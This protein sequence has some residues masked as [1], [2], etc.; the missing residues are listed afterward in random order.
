[1]SVL[2]NIKIKTVAVLLLSLL[3]VGTLVGGTV[4]YIVL[5]SNDATN[6]FTPVEV[7]S[8]PI[9]T[10]TGKIA[11]RNSG[12]ITA[13]LRAAVVVTW[14]AVDEEGNAT[15]LYHITSPV[16]G[17]NYSMGYDASGAWQKGSDGFW[18]HKAA[19]EAGATTAD[20]ITSVAKLTEA[21]EG[22]TLSVE[23]LTTGIQATPVSAVQDAWGVTLAGSAI[24]PN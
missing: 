5:R 7:D 15:D 13:Y 19:V 20:L 2:K 9:T 4:A 11:V 22:Y 12:E 16:E 3:I 17:V 24:Q 1:M 8:E 14:V 18:Y 21:P 23:V 6:T 10:G